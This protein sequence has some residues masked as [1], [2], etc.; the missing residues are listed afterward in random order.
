LDSPN[1]ADWA[2]NALAPAATDSNNSAL[3]V[4]LFDQ[5][6]EEGVGFTLEIPTGFTNIVVG[7]RSRAET[8]AGSNLGVVP[9]LYVR[10]MPDNAAVES[11]SAGTDMTTITMGT[12]NEFFQYDSQT[13]ALSTLGLV[14]GRVAQFELTRN[15]GA[16]GDILVGDW[17]LLEIRVS[18]T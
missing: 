4:R 13:I 15:T 11:W 10:E 2:V 12:S 3:V 14:A 5:T 9:K 16:G 8:S 6:T 18:F 1:N 17:A 7:L